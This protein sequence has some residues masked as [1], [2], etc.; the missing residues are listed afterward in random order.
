MPIFA[1]ILK[2]P[3]IRGIIIGILLVLTLGFGVLIGLKLNQFWPDTTYN[4]PDGK[5]SEVL[6]LLNYYYIKPLNDQTLTDE[7]ISCM[8]KSIDPHTFYI[9]KSEMEEV[10]DQM[11]GSFDGIGIEFQIIDDTLYVVT[12]LS[13]G[14]SE[15]AG[16]QMGDR[17]ITIEGENVAGVK[18]TSNDV[19]KKLRGKKGT[20]VKIEVRRH[21]F[22]KLLPFT[23]TR[24]AIPVHSVDFSYLVNDTLGYIKV[25]RFAETTYKE[26]RDN[27]NNLKK[28]GMKHLLLDLRGN[29]GGYLQ[30]AEY[31]A[32]AFLKENK[33]IVYTEGRTP[34]SKS[35]YEATAEIADFENGALIVLIDQG[36]ASASEIVSGAVQ[37]WDR[38]IIVGTR[39]FGKGLVQTQ[40]KLKDGSA[41]RIVV[42][43]YFTPSGRCIQKPFETSTEEYQNEVYKRIETGELYD[44]S[45]IKFPDS[46][47]YKTHKGRTVYGGGG[48]MPDFFTP[49]DTTSWSETLSEFLAN[50]L[51]RQFAIRYAE[52]NPQLKKQYLNGLAFAKQFQPTPE[53]LQ[54][55]LNFAKQQK[56]EIKKEDLTTSKLLINNYLKAYIGRAYFNDAGFYPSLH[57]QDN[58][59]LRGVSLLPEAI[60]L[61][62]NENPMP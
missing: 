52:A 35:R 53:M 3:M 46:L 22:S 24:D 38:G 7:A 29:P 13:G 5:F 60:K 21:G 62:Q 39:S 58:T 37:D 8:L 50:G 44:E 49:K 17:I 31:M 33:L 51:F 30:M 19:V 34:E 25:S 4:N 48:I 42:S 45:K 57:Q 40:R 36:S 16:I 15:R 26:F 10:E 61:I 9:P 56:I 55:M 28:Q 2:K 18:I 1:V 20:L 12:P 47:K 14:P 54:E 11:S 27:L 32:D 23:L 6:Q 43:R 59:F 41:V